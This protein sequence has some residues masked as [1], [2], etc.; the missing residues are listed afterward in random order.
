M[1]FLLSLIGILGV[2]TIYITFFITA[3]LLASPFNERLSIKFEKMNRGVARDEEPSIPRAVYNEIKKVL[4]Y[5]PALLLLALSSAVIS[6]IPLLN[7]AVPLLWALFSSYLV[8]FEF[9]SYPLDRRNLG[10]GEKLSYINRNLP[11][12]LGLGLMTSFAVL[13][14]VINLIVIPSAVVASTAM[15][16]DNEPSGDDQLEREGEQEER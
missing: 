12:S 11:S 15:V 6:M 5:I 4:I 14:P 7:L 10:V 9:L 1:W 16:I 8:A 3:S 13:L 2:G